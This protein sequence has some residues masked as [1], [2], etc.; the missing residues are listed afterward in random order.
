MVTSSRGDFLEQARKII[1]MKI[2]HDNR[3]GTYKY[4]H[5]NILQIQ[6]TEC[7][8]HPWGTVHWQQESCRETVGLNW[9]GPHS[10]QVWAHKGTI[11]QKISTATNVKI[12]Y[13]KSISLTWQHRCSSKLVCWVP[14]RKWEMRNWLSW[15][16][17]LRPSAEDTS[18]GESLLRWWKGGRFPQYWIAQRVMLEQ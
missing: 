3:W 9:C 4:Q 5:N 8:R 17:W 2:P 13:W 10:V 14:W 7:Q 18:W 16:P 15:W 6:S 1:T 11:L 12:F